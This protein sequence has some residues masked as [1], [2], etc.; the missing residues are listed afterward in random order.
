[1]KRYG[2]RYFWFFVGVLINS[3]GVAFITKASL[4]T[5]PISSVP[6]V[7]SF[8]FPLTL[9]QFTFLL[10][11]LFLLLQIAL[12]GRKFPPL[13]LLQLA[14]TAV[15]SGFLDVSMAL[16]SWLQPAGLAEKLVSLLAGCAVLALGI[17]I[18]VA[19]DILVV[20]GE[21][22]VRAIALVSGKKFGSVKVAFDVALVLIAVALSLW[23]FH[24][25]HGVREGTVLA[26]LG[27]G[28]FLGLF[29]RQWQ[30]VLDRF[31][32]KAA[33]TETPNEAA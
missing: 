15:F 20:P 21:G 23:F 29:V 31:L 22:I 16:L 4:G 5:S 11:S 24:G 19:P 1:M 33:R 32:G 27:V 26:A 17:A 25:L 8:Q 2:F 30:G 28:K 13:Q 10:N 14:A 12:L 9:G 7:L 18:E 3:F 6:Y